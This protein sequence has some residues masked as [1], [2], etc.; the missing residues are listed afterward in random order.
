MNPN[1]L[2]R[3]LLTALVIASA[4]QIPGCALSVE[5]RMQDVM[6]SMST[7]EFEA[8]IAAAQPGV[9]RVQTRTVQK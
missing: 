7:P 8:A 3:A 6:D 2:R 5:N 1:F 9:P 4:S